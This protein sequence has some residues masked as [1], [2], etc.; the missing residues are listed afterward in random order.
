MYETVC[1]C[2]YYMDLGALCYD[3]EGSEVPCTCG[4][5]E[6]ENNFDDSTMCDDCKCQM[7]DTCTGSVF[8]MTCSEIYY[9]DPP[10]NDGDYA[11]DTGLCTDSSV[12]KLLLPLPLTPAE[13]V[14][15]RNNQSIK[16]IGHCS[17]L[18]L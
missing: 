9:L 12:S 4:L 15:G 16:S 2:D 6:D 11:L 5:I 3:D 10:N 17:P 13:L 18:H 14:V 1:I 7:A 8:G